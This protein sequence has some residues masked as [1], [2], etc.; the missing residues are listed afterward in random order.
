MKF[1]VKVLAAAAVFAVAGCQKEAK[2][3]PIRGAWKPTME[4]PAIKKYPVCAPKDLSQMQDDDV[5][6][7]VNGVAL[8]KGDLG[9]ALKRYWWDLSLNKMARAGENSRK[10]R[11]FG[12]SYINKFIGTQLFVWEAR[13]LRLLN[14]QMVRAYVDAG[15]KATARKYRVSVSALASEIPGG[16]NALKRALEDMAWAG[17]YIAS[18]VTV[19][20]VI[21]DSMVSNVLAQIEDENKAIAVTNAAN[22]AKIIELHK[23]VVKGEDFGKIVD[24]YGV[25]GLEKGKGGYWDSYMTAMDIPPLIEKNVFPLEKGGIT[26]VLEDEDGYYFIKLIDKRIIPQ[27]TNVAAVIEYDMGR[28][29]LPKE[30]Y[31]VLSDP[32]GLKEQ[33]QGQMQQEA[34]T[35]RRTELLESAYV[36]YPY[37]NKIWNKPKKEKNKKNKAY[38]KQKRAA[39]KVKRAME[40][41]KNPKKIFAEEKK[42]RERKNADRSKKAKEN[43]KPASSAKSMNMNG[44]LQMKKE[45]K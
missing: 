38:R 39:M 41:G 4:N 28:M 37:G 30:E 14:E 5:I 26:D 25:E 2:R 13:R 9:L 10:Y 45:V 42:K 43:K 22:R 15:V 35:K 36:A 21:S 23:R 3:A 33:M 29:F 11:M 19:K 32:V 24:T 40:A 1:V 8:T 27:P 7:A 20:T 31:V 34:N 18:N 44:N 6:V 16:L 12:R 17:A